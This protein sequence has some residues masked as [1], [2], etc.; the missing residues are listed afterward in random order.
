MRSA[1][2]FTYSYRGSPFSW[3]QQP[4]V[5]VHVDSFARGEPQPPAGLASCRI[6]HPQSYRAPASEQTF[7]N[8]PI[9]SMR[10]RTVWPG[11]NH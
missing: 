10:V 3:H 4:P 8:S 2:I 9:P 11:F 6:T 1:Y 7:T 5:W